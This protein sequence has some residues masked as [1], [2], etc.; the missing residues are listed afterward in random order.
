MMTVWTSRWFEASGAAVCDRDGPAYEWASSWG[1]VLI[2]CEHAGG[3]EK[4]WLGQ[5]E[6]ET[7][8]VNLMI[9]ELV[10]PA[11]EERREQKN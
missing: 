4:T 1:A 11:V 7:L 6:L 5:E 10:V 2:R 8:P 3:S 9:A